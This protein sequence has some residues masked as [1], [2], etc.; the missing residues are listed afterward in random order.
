[1]KYMVCYLLEGEVLEYHTDLTARVAR[2]FQS[3][4]ISQ[5]IAPHITLKPPFDTER[6]EEVE[7]AMKEVAN[8][9]SAPLIT[10]AGFEQFKQRTIFLGVQPSTEAVECITDLV[11]RLEN[12]SWM[13]EN[14]REITKT[15]HATLATH[16]IQRQY[17][18]VWEYISK[19]PA[20]YFETTLSNI[21]IL[22][23]LDKRWYTHKRFVL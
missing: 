14:D 10:I 4:P 6:I 9:Y 21:T 17:D 13:P 20:P 12:I 5:R 22:Y 8:T 19:E 18:V 16:N 7:E 23:N 1:M 3:R 11:S 15:L 2:E